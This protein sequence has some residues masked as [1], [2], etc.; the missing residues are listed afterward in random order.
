MSLDPA[1]PVE[2]PAI[3]ARRQA[4]TKA[5]IRNLR[6]RIESHPFLGSSRKGM[7][8]SNPGSL[9]S[10]STRSPMMLRCT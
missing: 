3:D 9:G 10:P 8:L 4:A 5:S 2:R 7:F 1:P 6:L